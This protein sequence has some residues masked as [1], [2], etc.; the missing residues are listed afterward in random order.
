LLGYAESEGE[1][2]EARVLEKPK[3]GVVIV[4]FNSQD[5]IVRCLASLFSAELG[6]ALEIVVIDNASTDATVERV[7]RWGAELDRKLQAPASKQA[8][9]AIAGDDPIQTWG[10]NTLTLILSPRNGGYA[11]GVNLGLAAL[12]VRPDVSAFWIL[13]PDCMVPAATPAKFLAFAVN[14]RFGLASSRCLFLEDPELIQTDGGMVSRRTGVCS[15]ANARKPSSSTEPPSEG[16]LD[17]LTG[18]NLLVSRA[19]LEAVGPMPELYFLYYEEVDWA[20]RRG[21][22]TLR[23]ISDAPVYHEGGTSI[24]SGVLARRATPFSNYFNHRNR[25]LFVRAY[26]PQ[27]V[28][29][30]LLWSLG[31]AIQ[32]WIKVGPAEALAI[33]RGAFDFSPPPRVLARLSDPSA[34]IAAFKAHDRA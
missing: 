31:K 34:R 27:S 19:F 18:A 3:L 5:V 16:D 24:G 32:T 8:A 11:Y 26:M 33:I 28:G 22:F 1:F 29:A 21:S 13:N 6:E 30:A 14:E 12:R 15:S 20:F 10:T 9:D 23:L 4:T 17:Y 7:K 25:I 2:E